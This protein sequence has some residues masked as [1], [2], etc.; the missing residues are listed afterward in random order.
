MSEL[1]EMVKNTISQMIQTVNQLLDEKKYDQAWEVVQTVDN[2]LESLFSMAPPGVEGFVNHYKALVIMEAYSDAIRNN[3]GTISKW[4]NLLSDGYSAA[5]RALELM[6][7]YVPS[8]KLYP[9]FAKLQSSQSDNNIKLHCEQG[10]QYRKDRNYLSAIQ[11]YDQALILMKSSNNLDKQLEGIL[12]LQIAT[13]ITNGHHYAAC[14]ADGDEG[15][16]LQNYELQN[17]LMDKFTALM[18]RGYKEA[19][20]A[21]QMLPENA[22]AIKLLNYYEEMRLNASFMFE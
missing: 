10:D 4:K 8:Q 15:Y 18:P 22:Q 12:H 11:S 17:Q 21:A 5:A 16:E 7:Q 1:E 9:A 14:W 6:P 19:K 3:A 20:I 13:S 2:G